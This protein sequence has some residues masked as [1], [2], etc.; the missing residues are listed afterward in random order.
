VYGLVD[1]VADVGMDVLMLCPNLYMLPGWDSEHCPFWREEGLTKDFLPYKAM[2]SARDF[3]VS[4]HDMFALSLQ[5]ARE[6]N[7][8]VFLSWRMNE[9]HF[10]ERPDS[11][12]ASPFWRDHPEYRIGGPDVLS[13]GNYH[14]RPLLCLDFSHEA[15]RDYQ[16]GFIEELLE[17]YEVDGIE[18]DFLRFP[19]FF[20]KEK[21]FEEKAEIMT[22][23]V[24]RIRRRMDAKGLH[25]PLCVRIGNAYQINLE[26]GLDISAWVEEGLVDML[27]LCASFRTGLDNE[28]ERFRKE[29]PKVG[30]YGEIAD[31]AGFRR[32]KDGTRETWKMPREMTHATAH[33][34]LERGADGIS[35][36]NYVYA[37]GKGVVEHMEPLHGIA[38]KEYL[39]Q[40]DKHYHLVS[41]GAHLFRE[42]FDQTNWSRQMPARVHPGSS[43][44]LSVP[45][46]DQNPQ[47]KFNTAILRI[48]SRDARLKSLPVQAYLD[49]EPLRETVFRGQLSKPLGVD[50]GLSDNEEY[51]RDYLVPIEGLKKGLNYFEFHLIRGENPV[52][53]D[54]LELKLF[55]DKL[56]P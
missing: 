34:F 23:F 5:R 51:H 9:G 41:G 42:I 54:I 7:L 39:S 11:P 25:I 13:D 15:V 32:L 2:N 27:N 46:A 47:E 21:A 31:K 50:A 40:Q 6:R 43:A 33:S 49:G 24:R 53:I 16:F 36:F 17:R 12:T 14:S 30:L 28:M 44:F 26:L 45:L 20:P 10:L 48:H 18:L 22:A 37:R 3:I 52:L 8:D 56:N 55:R 35:F 1:E 19:A 38:D 29:F 4:G